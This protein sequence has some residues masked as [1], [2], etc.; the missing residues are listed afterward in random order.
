[1]LSHL[2]SAEENQRLVVLLKKGNQ[3]A[4]GLLYDKYA[5]AL[6]GIIVR[7]TNDQEL[8]EKFYILSF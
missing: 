4:L 7:I 6:F 5:P 8:A 2:H 3:Q 1:M